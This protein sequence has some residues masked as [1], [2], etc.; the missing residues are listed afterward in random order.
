MR[1]NGNAQS[2]TSNFRPKWVFRSNF[3]I[4]TAD[5]L[6]STLNNNF[7]EYLATASIQSPPGDPRTVFPLSQG[8]P[9]FQFTAAQDGSV[10]FFGTNYSGRNASWFDPHMR[11]PYTMNWSGG[12]QYQM[13]GTWLAELQYQGTA[14][15]GLLNNWDINV[16][17]L[18]VSTDPVRLT[19]TTMSS[20]PS[21]RD[22]KSTRLNSSHTS[23]SRMPSS[24]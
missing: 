12:F 11:M 18:K 13:T 2:R 1:I 17:P 23:V 7:E 5:L 9:S 4:I 21:A 20:L 22:R 16:L 3:G 10:P 14:G 19:A 15:V 6:T 24:A 8:P